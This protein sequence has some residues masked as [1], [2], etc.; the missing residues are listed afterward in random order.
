MKAFKIAARP[1]GA[2]DIGAGRYE[3][4]IHAEL[5]HPNVLRVFQ[6]F[7]LQRCMA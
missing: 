1:D 6:Y 5:R 7:E 2:M 4:H 3:F